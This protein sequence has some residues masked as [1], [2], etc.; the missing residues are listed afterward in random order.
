MI[1]SLIHTAFDPLPYVLFS[2]AS[3][4]AGL[5]IEVRTTI[6]GKGRPSRVL[7]QR[8]IG[9]ERRAE[10]PRPSHPRACPAR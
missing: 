5:L 10:S 1:G 4:A 8:S 6:K 7:P 2:L 9:T 3:I